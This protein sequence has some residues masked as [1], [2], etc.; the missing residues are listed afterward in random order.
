ML[1]D[2]PISDD[3]EFF[4]CERIPVPTAMATAALAEVS[5]CEACG[6][7]DVPFDWVLEDT[8]NRRGKVEFL[9]EAPLRCLA[10]GAPITERPTW[11]GAGFR[12]RFRVDGKRVL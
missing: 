2:D 9:L 6:E 4:E 12:L 3:P 1:S 11:L 7:T 5:G 8:L 10:C